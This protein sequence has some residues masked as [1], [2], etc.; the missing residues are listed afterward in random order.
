MFQPNPPL[1][2]FVQS[3]SPVVGM[4]ATRTDVENSPVGSNS[5]PPFPEKPLPATS[6]IREKGE[7]EWQ[8]VGKAKGKTQAAEPRPTLKTA[9]DTNSPTPST[10][11]KGDSPASYSEKLREKMIRYEP[12]FEKKEKLQLLKESLKTKRQRKENK[13]LLFGTVFPCHKIASNGP[14]P[15]CQIIKPSFITYDST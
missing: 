7:G 1:V 12:S 9:N 8:V 13:H 5:Q 2:E 15:M 10:S 6:V 14:S 11:A 3:V 4:P